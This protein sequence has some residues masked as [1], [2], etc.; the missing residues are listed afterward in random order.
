MKSETDKKEI[1]KEYVSK[2]LSEYISIGFMIIFIPIEN[3]QKGIR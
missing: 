1:L 2:D 3:R